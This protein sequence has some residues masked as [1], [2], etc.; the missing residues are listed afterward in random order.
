MKKNA[1]L[2]ALSLLLS[3]CGGGSS[4]H[5]TPQDEAASKPSSAQDDGKDF[6]TL[7][8]K[9]QRFETDFRPYG[10]NVNGILNVSGNTTVNG[11]RLA[12]SETYMISG[13][14]VQHSFYGGAQFANDP[15]NYWF[16]RGEITP[17]VPQTG[18]AIYRG[19]ALLSKHDVR[20]AEIGS[21]YL[22]ADFGAKTVNGH[23]QSAHHEVKFKADIVNGQDGITRLQGDKEVNI[24]GRFFGPKAREIGGRV[25]DYK[26][27]VEGVFGGRTE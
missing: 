15:V 23:L 26:Q 16:Y 11:K 1:Y 25:Q 3:A 8:I 20:E 6:R 18:Q 5:I 22:A 24:D 12:P 4:N 10:L 9:G 14:H 17:E 13:S 7:I 19:H 27:H 21:A 2:L